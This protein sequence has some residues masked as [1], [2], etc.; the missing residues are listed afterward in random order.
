MQAN[1][2]GEEEAILKYNITYGVKSELMKM[3]N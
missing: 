2:Q 1:K 3:N